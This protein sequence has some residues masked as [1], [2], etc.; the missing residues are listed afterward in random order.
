MK[1]VIDFYGNIKVPG[2]KKLLR[3]MKLTVLF[4]LIFVESVLASMTYSQTKT[5][6]I[7]MVDAKVKE[8]LAKIED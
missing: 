7:N 1:K 6:T 5:L 3:L 2:L 4:F 8:V